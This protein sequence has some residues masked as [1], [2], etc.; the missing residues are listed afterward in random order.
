[1]LFTLFGNGIAEQR[2]VVRLWVR[3]FLVVA[4]F[5]VDV[6]GVVVR[7]VV[8]DSELEPELGLLGHT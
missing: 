8:S 2:R 6:D 4:A 5:V 3:S 1:M 7:V